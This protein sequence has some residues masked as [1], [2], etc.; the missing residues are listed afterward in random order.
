MFINLLG[1]FAAFENSLRKERQLQGIAKLK[2]R[3][4]R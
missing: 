2:A 4:G 3:G 1:T